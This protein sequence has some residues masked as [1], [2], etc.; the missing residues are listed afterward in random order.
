MK[1]TKCDRCGIHDISEGGV[2]DVDNT[3]FSK[4]GYWF[5][6]NITASGQDICVA[7]VIAFEKFMKWDK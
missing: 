7:C 5:G 3:P 2:V 6:S 4:I 1:R